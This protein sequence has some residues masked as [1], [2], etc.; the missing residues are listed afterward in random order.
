MLYLTFEFT[1]VATIPLISELAP[2]ARGT[3]MALYLTAA[4]AG[5]ALGSLIG[6]RLWAADGLPLNAGVSAALMALAVA[7]MW[8]VVRERGAA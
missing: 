6:P 3:V 2:T 5:R 8:L 4:A 1:I 7:I